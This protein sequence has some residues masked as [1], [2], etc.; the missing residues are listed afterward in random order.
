MAPAKRPTQ[1]VVPSKPS[2]RYLLRSKPSSSKDTSQSPTPDLLED[3]ANLPLRPKETA[4]AALRRNSRD[5]EQR[6]NTDELSECDAFGNSAGN[7]SLV[8]DEEE[9]VHEEKEEL[10]SSDDGSY[11]GEEELDDHISDDEALVTEEEQAT[12]ISHTAVDQELQKVG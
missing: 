1:K 3:H 8:E 12:P 4:S 6:D 5:S 7:E 9:D 2:H 11:V 10:V